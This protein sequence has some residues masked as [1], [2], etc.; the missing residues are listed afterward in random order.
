MK[1]WKT[2]TSIILSVKVSKLSSMMH[3]QEPNSN[4]SFSI[5]GTKTYVR[6]HINQL[7]HSTTCRQLSNHSSP[8]GHHLKLRFKI[9]LVKSTLGLQ[10]TLMVCLLLELESTPPSLSAHNSTT[11]LFHQVWTQM[12][13][14]TTSVITLLILIEIFSRIQFCA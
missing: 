8:I 10:T 13:F 9:T 5:D 14:S 2:Q 7:F 1:I 11:S 4:G 3:K 6:R 12:L